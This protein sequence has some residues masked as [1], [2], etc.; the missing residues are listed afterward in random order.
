MASA[1]IISFKRITMSKFIIF[2]IQL[3]PDSEETHE[4]GVLGYR[5]LFSKLKEL[6]IE[7]KKNKTTASFHYPLPGDTYIGPKDFK[8][9]A[10]YVAG[11]FVRYIKTEKLKDLHTGKTIFSSGSKTAISS[12][13]DIPFVFDTSRHLLAIDKQHLPANALTIEI[14]NRFFEKIAQDNFPNHNLEINLISE[15]K[16]LEEIFK[17]AVA[18]GK[19]D[20]NLSF[21]NGTPI[22]NLLRELQDNRAQLNVHAS[23]GKKGRMP[24][25]P[26][27]LKEILLAAT[28]YGKSSISYFVRNENG[29]ERKKTY[30]SE[31]TPI[32]ISARRSASDASIDDFYARVAEKIEQINV[33]L[34]TLEQ[35]KA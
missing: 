31:E 2:N 12:F 3:L 5:K 28:T 27:F 18:Y 35:E 14:L 29:D 21:P 22:E 32:T 16:A 25:L 20:V 1:K 8:F 19:V 10:G 11:N 33:A 4:I 15:K 6:N 24:D 7:H 13:D 30:D 23:A 17:N 9:P 34:D 26:A